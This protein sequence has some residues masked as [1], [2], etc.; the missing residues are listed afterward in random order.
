MSSLSTATVAERAPSVLAVL[1][2][3]DAAGWLRESLAALAGQ[4]YPRLAVMAVDRASTDG[5]AELLTQALGEGRVIILGRDT[6][7]AGALRAALDLPVAREADYVLLVH[8]DVAIDPDG[9]AGLVEAA[10]G[11]PGIDR[12]GIVGAKVVDWDDPRELTDVGRSADRFGHPYS[13]LQ[14]GEI[15]QGQFDRVLEVLCVSSCTMLISRDAWQRAGEFDERLPGGHQDL[16]LCWRMRLAGFRVLMTPLARVRRRAA[17]PVEEGPSPGR[18][19]A[20]SMEDR[21]AI[22]AV[23]KNY[24]LL[25][26]LWVLP[27][28]LALGVVRV[29]YLLLGRRF[30]EAYDLAAAWGW[31]VAHLPGTLV[32]RRRVQKARRV[33]DRKLRR[34]MESAGL[35]LPRWFQTAERIWEEQRGLEDD[36]E[37]PASQRLR[38]R[39]ASFV[40]EHPVIVGSFLGLVVGGLAIRGLLSADPL[41]GGVLPSFPGHAAGFFAE[42]DSAYRTTPLGGSLPASP[43][44]AAMGGLSTLLF[45]NMSLAQKVML[46]G[47]PVLAAVL[48]YRAASRLTGRPGASVV[49]AAAYAASAIAMW[50]FSQGRLDLLLALAVLPAAVERLE[51]AFG[52]GEPADSGWRFIVGCGVTFAVLVAFLP[53]G[54][55]AIAVVVLVQLATSR[56]RARGLRLTLASLGTALVLLLPFVPTLIAGGGLA[57]TSYVGTT[58]V[59]RLGR[60]SFGSGPGTWEP[61]AFLPIAALISFALVGP[62]LRAPAIRA[63]LVATAG[64]TLS[65]LSAAGYLPAALSNPLAYGALAAVGEV[66]VIAFGLASVLTGLGR[67]SFG[68]RQVGTFLL[69]VVLAGGIALQGIVAMVGGWDV[70]G[71]AK[72]P[73]AWAVV[74]SSAKGDYRVLWVG[75]D[76]GRPFPAP[77]GDPE[78]VV[79]AGDATL[80]YALTDRGG[81]TVLDTARPLTGGGRGALQEAIGEVLSGTSS[82]GGALLAPFG[83]RFVVAGQGELPAASTTR[84]N[85]QV[86]L[87]LVSAS[88]LVIYRNAAVVPPAAVL[89]ATKAES[90]QIL[91]GTPSVT[92]ALSPVAA[93]PMKQVQGGW[94]GPP[95]G[96]FIALSTEFSGSWRISESTISPQES[97]GWATAFGGAGGSASVRFGMQWPRTVEMVLL[98]FAWAAALWITRKPVRR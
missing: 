95:R 7:T 78:G 43:A 83:V 3:R 91:S 19:N 32:R 39:T 63:A 44:L 20:R 50:S 66:M 56:S 97:F 29:I 59:G 1:V 86:D 45:G 17:A 53:G 34:F 54:A 49:A 51:V 90:N 87:N 61:A 76:D 4:T 82:H 70:G 89:K 35:R 46:M 47:A 14:P 21:A 36:E 24:S 18:R 81:V 5:S 85:A 64:L 94:D 12:V 96:G 84:L 74:Q 67:E 30:E 48:M 25:S 6:G 65:W 23:L 77:G 15:D 8:D 93:I 92:A 16:D 41:A 55:L 88:G 11:I 52:G 79:D 98:A 10:V 57:F 75:A 38:Q 13:P 40:G 71:V 73:A 80:R 22:T 9:V 42:L 27:L 72:I 58:D 37:Q 2:V 31:N 28:S 68:L 26:L 62:A 69:T 33:K 60:L